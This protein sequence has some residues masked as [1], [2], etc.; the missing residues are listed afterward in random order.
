[1]IEFQYFE[2][3][4]NSNESLNNLRAFMEKCNIPENQLK[5]TLVL[6]EETAK[7]INFQGSPTILVNG[8]D[9]YS[10]KKPDQLS[11]SCRLYKINNKS[12]GIL[13]SEYISQ[14][15]NEIINQNK[16]TFKLGN[17]SN[18]QS[19]NSNFQNSTLKECPICN[20]LGV[21]VKTE[22]VASLLYD[23]EKSTFVYEQFA[24]CMNSNCVTSYYSLDSD[25]SYRVDDIT[26]PL[27]YKANSDPVYACYCSKITREMVID[28]IKSHGA[29]NVQEINKITGAMKNP[30]CLHKNPLGK[31]CHKIIEKIITNSKEDIEQ[32][33]QPDSPMS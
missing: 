6:N 11:F 13:T 7:Q 2:G 3:C 27:W 29:K 18:L 23:K 9:L 28:A 10:G 26:V 19:N 22:T 16:T 5:I 14:R 30:D 32:R 15:Y 25:L 31:C 4:P 1:M 8:F 21:S 12:T 24:L 17:L 20:K 33:L